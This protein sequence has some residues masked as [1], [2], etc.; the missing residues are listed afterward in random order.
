MIDGRRS[1]EDMAVVLEKQRLM[2]RAEAIPAIR[3]FLTKMFDDANQQS[4]F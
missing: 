2:T 4:G 3:V 1:I